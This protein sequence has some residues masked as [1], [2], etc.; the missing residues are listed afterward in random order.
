M[1]PFLD[2]WQGALAAEQQA[3]FGYGL[4]GPHLDGGDQPRALTSQNAHEA[5]R[6]AIMAAMTAAGIE[7]VNAKADYPALYPVST[8]AQALAVAARLEDACATGWRVLYLAAAI[9]PSAAKQAG[10][11]DVAA[12]RTESQHGLTAAAISGARWRKIAGTVPATRAFPG[13]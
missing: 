1:N 4:I 3:V 8:S 10:Y 13:V 6:D 2:A 5:A 12:R 7:P 11:P 9:D